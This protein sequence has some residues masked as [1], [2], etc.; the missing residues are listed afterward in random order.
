MTTVKLPGLIDVHV[1]LREPGATRKED[2][3]TGTAAAL[4]GG[5]TCVLDMPN[6]TP[7]ITTAETL[8]AKKQLAARMPAAITAFTWAQVMTTCRRRTHSRRR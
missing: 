6:N 1:H 5:F 7:P 2:Y 4:A 8:A 3:S